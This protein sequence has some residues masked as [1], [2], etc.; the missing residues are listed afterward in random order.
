MEKY[1]MNE[2]NLKPPPL[3][4]VIKL[5][6][7]AWMALLSRMIIESFIHY[8]LWFLTDGLLA[9]CMLCLKRG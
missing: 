1:E 5:I 9:H 8:T 4:D 7:D 3:K 6:F 2:D